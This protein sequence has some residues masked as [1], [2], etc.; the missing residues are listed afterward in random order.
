MHY[1]EELFNMLFPDGTACDADLSQ[2]RA[3]ISAN[4]KQ[5]ARKLQRT[6]MT[7]FSCIVP[8]FQASLEDAL[9]RQTDLNHEES[10]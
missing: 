3:R 6:C 10:C 9:G 2:N 4:C 8:L 5:A 7:M 1:W